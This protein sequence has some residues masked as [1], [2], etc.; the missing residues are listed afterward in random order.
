MS[1]LQCIPVCS[2]MEIVKDFPDCTEDVLK[3]VEIFRSHKLLKAASYSQLSAAMHLAY[4]GNVRKAQKLISEA[5]SNLL[6]S[7]RDRHIILN[8]SVVAELLSSKPEIDKCLEKLN[9]ALFTVRDEFSRLTIHSNRLIC[10]WL[11]QDLNQAFHC[12]SIIESIFKAPDFGNRDIFWTVCFNVSAFLEEVGELEISRKFKS[13]L[14]NLNLENSCYQ[15][16]WKVRY[17]VGT[18]AEPEFNFL[19]QFK[20]HPAYLSHWLIDYEGLSELKAE[21]A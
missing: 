13:F 20:Y 8:N 2:L 14:S 1:H 5:E 10:F 3:S 6:S 15:N 16:Y 12:I 9:T 21:H 4:A 7:I 19:L 17:G 11:Q 18:E